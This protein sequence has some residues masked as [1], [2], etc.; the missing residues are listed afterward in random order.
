MPLLEVV[1]TPA[2]GR[3]GH[4]HRGRPSG[5]ALGKHVIVVRD[6]PGFYTT[7]ALPPYMNEAAAC[8]RRARPSRTWT[9]AHD[10]TSASRSGRCALLD[11]VGIDV[12][13]ARS[14]TCCT[15]RSASAWRRPASMARVIE[16]GRLGRKNGR[17]FYTLRR[18]QEA[19]GRVGLRAAAGRRR[20]AAARRA[21]DP[22]APGVRVPERG[23]AAACRKGS[24]ARRAT[25]T[26]AAIFGLGLPAVP[27]RALPL[28]RPPR[29][30]LRGSR[31]WRRL[32]DGTA[33][34]CPST[35][36]WRGPAF[37]A[38]ARSAHAMRRLTRVSRN[39]RVLLRPAAHRGAVG[40][41]A[42]FGPLLGKRS[43]GTTCR[44]W[45]RRTPPTRPARGAKAIRGRGANIFT[46]WVGDPD[47][48]GSA[49][50][51][52]AIL[53]ELGAEEVRI[54]TG[55]LGPPAEPQPGRALRHHAARPEHGAPPAACNCM[56]DTS[57]PL[58]MLRT[59]AGAAGEGVLLRGR[60]PR[61]PRRRRGELPGQGRAA[62]QAA[63]RGPAGRLDL[64]VHGGAGPRF[65][66]LEALGPAGGRP[67][68]SA[69]TPTPARS[70]TAPRPST[71][72]CSRS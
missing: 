38:T 42:R 45:R 19:R 66:V 29:R 8:S 6:G 7:R 11:E 57:P 21:R 49:V 46:Q 28:P 52:T 62:R 59:R 34:A 47:A 25:A 9:G 20:A 58:G 51:L 12:G 50:L 39:G 48:L 15:A 41:A 10:A 55:S 3:L 53:R 44:C 72:G 4:R 71:S 13:G 26:W 36:A 56:V 61:R 37:H 32:R 65:G 17:G 69:S 35:L 64:R 30:A 60:P 2:D 22:G 5:A 70:C 18:R 63:V 43:R 27:G 54:L 40:G 14:R 33:T 24:C 23:R 68:R 67:R 16:D 1:V 31:C